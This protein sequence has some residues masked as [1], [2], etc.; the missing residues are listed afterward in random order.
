ME[1]IL[2]SKFI[3]LAQDKLLPA[4]IVLVGGFIVLKIIMALLKKGLSKTTKIDAMLNKFIINAVRI[5]LWVILCVQVMHQ[6]GIDSTS[7]ITIFAAAGA[8]VAL[9][10]Q[11][12]LSNLASGIIIIF[13]QP[14][15]HGD[16]IQGG[17]LEGKVESIDLLY[18]TIHT[19]DNKVVS[20]PNSSLTSGNIVNF[21]KGGERRIDVTIGVAYDSDLEKAKSLLIGIAK[22]TGYYLEEK[23]IK[24]DIAEYGDSSITLRLRG[25]VKSQNY[26]AALDA[27]NNAIKPEFD[28]NEIEIPFPQMDVHKK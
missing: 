2:E 15:T 22:S 12:S 23:D 24:C 25:W 28:A 20:I 26:W 9:A 7:V 27:V 6:L 1:K 16:Y 10:L 5:A 8:A 4:L 21:Y 14:F 19:A 18:T 3:E 17:G 11:G 13:T